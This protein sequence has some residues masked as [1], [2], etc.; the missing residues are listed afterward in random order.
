MDR[1]SCCDEVIMTGEGEARFL[2]A[3]VRGALDASGIAIAATFAGAVSGEW[4]AVISMHVPAIAILLAVVSTVA[5]VV[6]LWLALRISIDRRLF[7]AL[8]RT[9]HDD[10]LAALD[11]ALLALGWIGT[12][13]TG[14][15]LEA[16]IRGTL[17]LTKLAMLVA[18][19]L[20]LILC[21]AIIGW[22]VVSTIPLSS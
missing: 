3:A 21:G 8:A 17:R 22:I 15:T 19:V 4:L 11:H 6:A 2:V 14:R 18:A 10:E 13:K 16:R 1:S 12:S 5:G 9:A 7:A 20:W